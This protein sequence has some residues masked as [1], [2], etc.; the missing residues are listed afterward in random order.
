M[1]NS[2]WPVIYVLPVEAG[3]G[4][5]YG[6]GLLEA[7]RHGLADRL[8]AI[9]VAPTFA[10][11]PWYADHPTAAGIRQESYLLKKVLPLVETTYP[12]RTD[13]A[14]RLLVGFSK[15]GWGA[16]SLLLRH[17]GVFGRAVAW[18]APLQMDA[19]GRYGSGPVFGTAE[20]FRHYQV[21]RLYRERADELRAGRARLVL[22]GYGGFRADTEK[23]HAELEMLRVPHVYRDGPQREH[24]WHSG[25]FAQA[26]ELL[27]EK[28]LQ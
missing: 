11:L 6:D 23:T 24:D 16:W 7:Q 22:L 27:L 13:A 12:A 2:P 14:G 10:Q 18:D 25:W 21:S 8:G 26:C 4:N 1:T 17:P 20:N 9:F 3:S 28:Q 15:S 19:P 5:Q